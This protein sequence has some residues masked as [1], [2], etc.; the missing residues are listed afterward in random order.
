MH[1][2]VSSDSHREDEDVLWSRHSPFSVQLSAKKQ[3]TN[4]KQIF[5]YIQRKHKKLIKHKI[6]TKQIFI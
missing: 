4:K 5:N 1:C 2:S 3:K 6:K